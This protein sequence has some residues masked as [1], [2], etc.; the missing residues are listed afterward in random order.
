MHHQVV[1]S[2]Q[3]DPL[4]NWGSKMSVL[5]SEDANTKLIID[6]RFSGT[7]YTYE[8]WQFV[9]CDATFRHIEFSSKRAFLPTLPSIIPNMS[10]EFPRSTPWVKSSWWHTKVHKVHFCTTRFWSTKGTD[11]VYLLLFLIISFAFLWW[12]HF[13]KPLMIRASVK[14]HKH[15]CKWANN[16][17]FYCTI[18]YIT[19]SFGGR[20]HKFNIL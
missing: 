14:C 17:G 7:K 13:C 2:W 19:W 3:L 5:K 12:C 6:P 11:C 1:I 10:T 4:F 15:E 20:R 16:S 8:H 18:A 9:P